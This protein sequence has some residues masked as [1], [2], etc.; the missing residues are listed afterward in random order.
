VNTRV[1]TRD[2]HGADLSFYYGT[3]VVSNSTIYCHGNASPVLLQAATTNDTCSVTLENVALVGDRAGTER[4]RTVRVYER[5]KLELRRVTATDLSFISA[6]DSTLA[7]RDSVISGGSR[8]TVP[9]GGKWEANHNLY[10]LESLSVGQESWKISG[11]EAYK[12]ATGQDADSRWM[13]LEHGKPLDENKGADPL[14][15]PSPAP[16]LASHQSMTTGRGE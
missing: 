8:I 4:A 14:L 3:H 1:V 11:F 12:T 13:K 16:P 5:C 6:K 10:D 7:I 2:I 9:A 15:L